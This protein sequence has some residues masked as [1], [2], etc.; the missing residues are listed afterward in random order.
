LFSLFVGYAALMLPFAGLSSLLVS[1]PCFPLVVA[2]VS[3]M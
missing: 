3:L 2:K 1:F